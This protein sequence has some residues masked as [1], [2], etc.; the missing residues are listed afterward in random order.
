MNKLMVGLVAFGMT[1]AT[2]AMAAEKK[3]G[4]DYAPGQNKAAGTSAKELAPGQRAKTG[5]KDAN[6]YAPGQ[7]A[8][9]ANAKSG[10]GNTGASA[11]T[12]GSR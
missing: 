6:D 10:T 7:K 1:L 2:G 4:Q 5:T 8:D 3:N 9:D 12:S 11:G